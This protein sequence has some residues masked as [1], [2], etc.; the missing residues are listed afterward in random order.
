MLDPEVPTK[1][2][3]GGALERKQQELREKRRRDDPTFTYEYE[4]LVKRAKECMLF[5][6]S[7][8]YYDSMTILEHK[9]FVE[10]YNSIEKERNK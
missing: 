1:Q 4:L 6:L 10:A 7:P 9:A 2:V 5:G 3:F 8:E